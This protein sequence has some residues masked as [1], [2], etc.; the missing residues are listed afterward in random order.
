MTHRPAL[1]ALAVVLIAGCG[2]GSSAGSTSSASAGPLRMVEQRHANGQL[3]AQGTVLDESGGGSLRHGQW[4]TWF[5]HG[6]LR[7]KG[8]YR[9]GAIAADQPW[10][11]WNADGS[12]RDDAG[13]RAD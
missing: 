12:V 5:D 9:R 4:Q 13:D 8:D 2:G 3:A 6:Q 1:L 10:R 7:W 11:E